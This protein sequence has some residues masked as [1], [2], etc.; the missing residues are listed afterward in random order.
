MSRLRNTFFGEGGP[1][2]V[3]RVIEAAGGIIAQRP[4]AANGSSIMLEVC[5]LEP[6]KRFPTPFLT[7]TLWLGSACSRE[8][9]DA[10]RN[11]YGYV[12]ART[13]DIGT[14]KITAQYAGHSILGLEG[15]SLRVLVIVAGPPAEVCRLLAQFVATGLVLA[16]AN[17]H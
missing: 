9:A 2:A 8:A 10:A 4:D 15:D 7:Q 14:A 13:P 3:R 16:A 5:L 11:R 6:S 17:L 12:L 1:I